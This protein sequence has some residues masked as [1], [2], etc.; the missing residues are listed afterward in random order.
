MLCRKSVTPALAI[1]VLKMPLL[2]KKLRTSSSVTNCGTA[3][4]TINRVRQNLG[5]FV[6]LSLMNID[7]RMPPKKVVKVAKK[8]QTNVHARTR[9]KE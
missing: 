6:F 5:N 4:V 3:I 2:E 1:I 9:A 8:A 7:I